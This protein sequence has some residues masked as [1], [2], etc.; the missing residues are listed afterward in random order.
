MKTI[1]V[2][3]A[4]EKRTSQQTSIQNI[5]AFLTGRFMG[6]GIVGVL[7]MLVG[8]LVLYTLVHF[9]HT[10]QNLAYFIQAV[11]SIELN[12]ICNKFFNW[13]DRPGHLLTQWVK[14]N[15]T[16]IG[17][18]LLNQLLFAFLIAQGMHYL[19]ATLIGVALATILNYIINDRFVFLPARA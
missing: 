8:I 18:V 19:I 6:F 1:H 5:L 12:F 4:A 15:T 10:N 13:R 14:F 3:K 7:I 2:S 11:V 17:T 16:K 9:F